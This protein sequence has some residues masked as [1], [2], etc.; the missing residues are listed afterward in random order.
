MSKA[1]PERVE[2][3]TKETGKETLKRH[4][5]PGNKK[6]RKVNLEEKY[7]LEKYRLEEAARKKV[8]GDVGL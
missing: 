7:R 5:G 6:G 8:A 3:S 1:A 4:S 2:G